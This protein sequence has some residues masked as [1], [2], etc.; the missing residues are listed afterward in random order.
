MI[1]VE[2]KSFH[3][4]FIQGITA[5]LIF[6]WVY[7]AVSKLVDFQLSHNRMLNQVFSNRIAGILAWAV[8]A[9]ELLISALLLF[10]KARLAGLYASLFLLISFTVYISLVMGNVFGR[11]P[12]SCGGVLEK[13]TWGQHLIF[14]L[15]FLLLAFIGVFYEIKKGGRMGKG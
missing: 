13:L 6:L 12:C 7:A 3:S 10:A 15:L 11:I 5:A 2:S 8:P 14:N 4:Y 9:S 1:T